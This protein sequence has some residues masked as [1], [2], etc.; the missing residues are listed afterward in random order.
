MKINRIFLLIAALTATVRAQLATG[1][2][3]I[4]SMVEERYYLSVY[5]KWRLVAEPDGFFTLSIRDLELGEDGDGDVVFAVDD[6]PPFHWSI[7]PADPNDPTVVKIK[8]SKLGWD[9]DIEWPVGK[10]RGKI[11]LG[12]Y[13]NPPN[14]LPIELFKFTPAE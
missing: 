5:D 7:E 9:A 11:Y 10:E 1:N 4:N 14:Y 12:E 6:R 2:Y 8:Y 13:Y 3:Y